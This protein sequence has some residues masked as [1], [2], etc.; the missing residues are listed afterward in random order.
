MLNKTIRTIYKNFKINRKWEKT[1]IT[2]VVEPHHDFTPHLHS[3]I[4]VRKEYVEQIIN[5]IKN[6]LKHFKMGKQ[7]DIQVIKDTKE[8][9]IL[10]NILKK[11]R[12]QKRRNV[13]FDE[14]VEKN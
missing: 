13:S 3:L 11:L 6:V 2:R 4:F 7:R 9:D 8:L 14:W 1:Y 10:V 5:H 12:I